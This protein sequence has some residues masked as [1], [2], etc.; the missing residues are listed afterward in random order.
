MFGFAK[1]NAAFEAS[2][3]RLAADLCDVRLLALLTADGLVRGCWPAS[4]DEDRLSAMSAATLSLG[5]R[6]VKE[7]KLGKL[8]YALQ[9]GEFGLHLVFMLDGEYGLAMNVRPDV[10]LDA[11]FAA[12]ER[13]L[14]PFCLELGIALSP[15][16]KLR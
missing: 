6:I 16:W 7:L 13:C 12:L 1:R 3:A 11:L 9:A 4:F 2:L 5:E 14:P 10:S 15:A 8:R